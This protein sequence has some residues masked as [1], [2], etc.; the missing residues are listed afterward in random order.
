MERDQY[1]RVTEL[2]KAFTDDYYSKI[3]QE[4]VQNAALRGTR[5]HQ[6]CHS[7]IK[8]LWQPDITEEEQLYVDSF[9][10]WFNKENPEYVLA[11]ERFYCDKYFFSGQIDYLFKGKKD[12]HYLLVDLKT[13]QAAQKS[14]GIQLAAYAYLA[15]QNGFSIEEAKVVRLCKKGKNPTIHCYDNLPE[16][17]DLFEGFLKIYNFF[18]Y[19]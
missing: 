12:N 14:W 15:N 7:Y 2:L 11:E 8:K 6:F 16:L 9:S 10:R 5:V 13:P 4:V 18:K 1:P 17:W 3:N 19:K